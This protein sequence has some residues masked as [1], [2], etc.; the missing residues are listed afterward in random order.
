MCIAEIV[1]ILSLDK[2][3]Q[4]GVMGACR[5]HRLKVGGSSP[6]GGGAS[7][8]LEVGKDGDMKGAEKKADNEIVVG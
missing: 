1:C 4:S 8:M 5:S 2:N 3:W 7:L 6:V